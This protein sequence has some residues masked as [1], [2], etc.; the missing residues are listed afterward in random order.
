MNPR[1][2]GF[3]LLILAARGWAQPPGEDPIARNVFPPEL[4][5]KYS[6]EIGLDDR[7][8][9][10]I[11]DHVQGVQSK[12][13]DAQWNLQE[14]SQKLVRLLQA[15]PVNESAVLAEVDKVLALEREIKRAQ[16]SLLVKIK[17]LLSEPQQAKLLELRKRTE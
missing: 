16:I 13:L 10:A 8:R 15:Q 2:A 14:E 9:A 11:K 3:L 6:Q 17:N 1:I 7:Q 5:M 4:V 12:F